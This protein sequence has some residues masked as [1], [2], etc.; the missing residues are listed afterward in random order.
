MAQ[1]L[2]LLHSLPWANNLILPS[3]LA[4]LLLTSVHSHSLEELPQQQRLSYKDM[5]LRHPTDW[6]AHYNH[7]GV[8]MKVS[9][10]KQGVRMKLLGSRPP[11]CHN[12]C[13]KCPGQCVARPTDMGG[14]HDVGES[15]LW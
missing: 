12:E 3:L 4:L 1:P 13:P 15:A 8:V 10:W 7:K 11:Q 2:L 14:A 6:V 9:K 5:S